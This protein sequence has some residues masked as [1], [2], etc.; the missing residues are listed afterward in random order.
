MKSEFIDF[1]KLPFRFYSTVFRDEILIYRHEKVLYAISG[2]CPHF[3]G[4]LEYEKGALN[5]YW[6]GWNFDAFTH[7]CK[8][9]KINLKIKSYFVTE[10]NEFKVAINDSSI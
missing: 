8:N 10:I 1:K 2:F 7:Y 6:H 5:C 9:R 3:G 4:P